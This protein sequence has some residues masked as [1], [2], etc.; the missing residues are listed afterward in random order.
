MRFVDSDLRA[1]LD[2]AHVVFLDCDGVIFDSNG[3]KCRAMDRVLSDYPDNLREQMATYWRNNGGMS[4]RVKFEYFFRELTQSPDWQS[5]TDLAVARFG[6]YSLEGFLDVEPLERALVFARQIGRERLVVV[7]GADQ[8]E[9]ALV[10]HRKQLQHLF[11]EVLGA[12]V[13]KQELVE[14]VLAERGVGVDA[15]LLIGDG[16]RDFEVCQR[17]GMHFVYLNEYSEWEG[18]AEALA[19]APDVRWANRWSELLVAAGFAD[20]G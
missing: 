9:L 7:S 2:A 17:L 14:R 11:S 16:A 20:G 13:K 6:G 19:D 5:L 1:R 15:A 10:F 18:A 3:F 8:A 4:R 12:P